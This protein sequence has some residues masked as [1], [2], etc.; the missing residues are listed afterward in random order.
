MYSGLGDGVGGGMIESG[1]G[2]GKIVGWSEE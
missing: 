2:E 1:G